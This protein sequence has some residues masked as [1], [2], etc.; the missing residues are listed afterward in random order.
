MLF[1]SLC[2]FQ[3]DS[4]FE[5]HQIKQSRDVHHLNNLYG[6]WMLNSCQGGLATPN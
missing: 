2:F 1:P 4:S 3:E 6:R 5:R